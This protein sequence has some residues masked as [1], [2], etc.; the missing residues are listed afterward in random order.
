ML[1]AAT[2]RVEAPPRLLFGPGPSGVD[3]RAYEA[4]AQP[5][6]G[7]RDPY[8][9]R[10]MSEI[11]SGLRSV[12][13][14]TN[15]KTF[16]VPA[17]GSGAMETAVVNF[18]RP[19]SKFA[20]F[21]AGHFANRIALMG[22]RQGAT[23]VKLEK[24]WGE[25]FTAEEAE[26]FL[27]RERPEVVSFVQAETSTGAYQTGRAIAPAAKALGAL[28]IADTVTSLGAM[29]VELDSVGVDVSFSCSQKGLSCPAGLS[30]I[31]VSPAAWDKL[32]ASQEESPSWYFDL[33]LMAQYF[34][35]PHTYHHTPSTP[36][37]YAMHQGLAVIEEEGIQERWTR[38]RR[39][40][41]RMLA[42]LQKLGF[43]PLVKN[44][45]NRIWHVIAVVPPQGANEAEIRQRLLDK[46]NI[47]IASGLG[48]LAGKI[49][50]I[51]VMGPLA[52]DAN[53]D[54]FLDAIAA[55]M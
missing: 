44:P 41:E 24:P 54:L 25:V 30:P 2:K 33:K 14:T 29:P 7:I 28:L 5:V 17:S 39:A 49:L 11:R 42:G 10:V 53:V 48:Q 34:D 37:Y 9:F 27:N 12:F 16:T 45:E 35:P 55:C 43:E 4:M 36:L 38:H 6:L 50:R 31:S 51:G 20:V 26:E 23:V 47:E 8:F 3:P 18:I 32:S 1:T 40:S 22:A 15:E 21:A 13:G 19:G 46:H 52:T